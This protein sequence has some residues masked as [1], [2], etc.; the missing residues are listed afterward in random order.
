[1]SL[2]HQRRYTDEA[3]LGWA[4]EE[5]RAG[6]VWRVSA[7][8]VPLRA[9]TRATTGFGVFAFLALPARGDCWAGGFHPCGAISSTRLLRGW[10]CGGAGLWRDVTKRLFPYW[11]DDFKEGVCSQVRLPHRHDVSI[12]VSPTVSPSPSLP[13]E[14]PSPS[15]PLRLPHRLSLSPKQVFATSLFMFVA[16]LSTAATFGVGTAVLTNGAIGPLEMILSSSICGV[17]YALSS[18][19]P[20]ALPAFGG[21]H[22]GFTGVLFGYAPALAHIIYHA[23]HASHTSC[24]TCTMRHASRASCISCVSCLREREQRSRGG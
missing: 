18:G 20:V 17:I 11:V 19:Q 10:V 7:L 12:T 5:G 16:C 13:T 15:R 14:S 4:R 6:H 24:V 3:L 8:V 1:V 9:T 22:L 2:K 21:V 23:S